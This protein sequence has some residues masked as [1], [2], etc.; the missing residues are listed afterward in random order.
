[1]ARDEWFSCLRSIL[2]FCKDNIIKKSAIPKLLG[3]PKAILKIKKKCIILNDSNNLFKCSALSIRKK[4]RH[5]FSS[6]AEWC[7]SDEMS[8]MSKQLC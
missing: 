6:Y 5:C 1:M 3:S 2:I 7:Q 4:F 8:H